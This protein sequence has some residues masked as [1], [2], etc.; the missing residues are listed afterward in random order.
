M[1][2]AWLAPLFLHAIQSLGGV[3]ANQC[4]N[5]NQA[6]QDGSPDSA[7]VFASNYNHKTLIVLPNALSSYQVGTASTSQSPKTQFECSIFL[8][9]ARMLFL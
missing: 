2:P 8:F 5:S 7:V 9:L 3:S 1:N 6:F 4:E